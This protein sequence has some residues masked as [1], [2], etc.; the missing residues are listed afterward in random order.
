MVRI[1]VMLQANDRFSEIDNYLRTCS[2]W[3][4]SDLLAGLVQLVTGIERPRTNSRKERAHRS[5]TLF[6]RREI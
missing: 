6:H 3:Q 2:R 1:A 5:H 4:L